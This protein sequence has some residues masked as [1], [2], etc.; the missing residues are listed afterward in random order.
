[1][2]TSHRHV[3]TA[4][5]RR[6]SA[7]A[8]IGSMLSGAGLWYARA[9]NHRAG[10]TVRAMGGS[11][12]CSP[13]RTPTGFRFVPFRVALWK[14]K[15][16]GWRIARDVN[17]PSQSGIGVAESPQRLDPQQADKTVRKQTN[18]LARLLLSVA[19]WEHSTVAS[20]G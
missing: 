16:R 12:R 14:N 4:L 11:G 13:P 8:C 3:K 7:H 9:P 18:P 1:P 19:M 2:S 20:H 6:L 17:A 10:D 15:H 5:D